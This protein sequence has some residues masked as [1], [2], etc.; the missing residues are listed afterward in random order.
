MTSFFDDL[1][2]DEMGS[3]A[4]AKK[5]SH[6]RKDPAEVYGDAIR[7]IITGVGFLVVSMVLFITNVAN[8]GTWWWAMLFPAFSFLARGISDLL[9]SK[10]MENR[11]TG[12]VIGDAPTTLFRGGVHSA[13]PPRSADSILPESKYATGDLVPPS[14]TDST[15]RLL[16][17]DKEGKTMTLPKK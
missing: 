4:K 3:K 7:N 16:E 15:T 12:R 14:V 10:R 11:Q 17:I 2:L 9:K 8:G 1:G 5:G 13:L 6:R